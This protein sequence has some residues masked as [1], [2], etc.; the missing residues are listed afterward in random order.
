[1]KFLYLRNSRLRIGRSANGISS[2]AKVRGNFE[3]TNWLTSSSGSV[4]QLS[5]LAPQVERVNNRQQET[6]QRNWATWIFFTDF[7]NVHRARSRWLCDEL[8]D[9]IFGGAGT[10]LR[11]HVARKIQVGCAAGLFEDLARGVNSHNGRDEM[12][13]YVECRETILLRH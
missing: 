2:A 4:W 5:I 13:K 3:N 1:M 6:I 11:R 10:W 7:Y 12:T 9:A 8:R